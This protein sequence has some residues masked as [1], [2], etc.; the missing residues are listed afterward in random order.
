MRKLILTGAA[1]ASLLAIPALAEC[2]AYHQLSD[3]E[4]AKES[5]KFFFAECLDGK[6][7]RTT[8]NY[9]HAETTTTARD[10]IWDN[11]LNMI[12]VEMAVR[13]AMNDRERK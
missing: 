8:R 7:V 9:N 4:K 5:T 3:R 11:L 10:S 13:R 2:D 12:Y 1:L 6:D